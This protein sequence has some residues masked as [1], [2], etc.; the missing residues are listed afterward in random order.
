[1]HRSINND[2]YCCLFINIV[3]LSEY[4]CECFGFIYE[5]NSFFTRNN[6]SVKYIELQ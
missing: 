6:F 5:I 4:S 2:F 3:N 1:M